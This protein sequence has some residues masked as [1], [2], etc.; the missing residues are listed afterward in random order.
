MPSD[1]S[2][3]V[4][5]LAL[6]PPNQL[7]LIPTPAEYVE[8]C[9]QAGRSTKRYGREWILGQG[10][11]DDQLLT[12]RI[13][14]RGA[15]GV[16]EVYD[17]SIKD[18]RPMAVPAG[19]AVSYVVNLVTLKLAVQPRGSE[20]KL[21]GLIGAFRALLS[22]DREMW[23]VSIPGKVAITYTEW[24]ETVDKVTEVKFHLRKP[25][26]HY[27]DTP[28]LQALLDQAEA[29]SARLR[30]R[31]S[32]G[33]DVSSPFVTQSMKHV[34][35]GYGDAVL[36]GQRQG[37]AGLSETI[38]NSQLNSEESGFAAP[39]SENGEVSADTLTKVLAGADNASGVSQ[40]DSS[41]QEQQSASKQ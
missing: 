24:L 12:G 6:T 1:R 32:E 21:N 36:V 19:L 39:A 9:L 25:N 3:K 4:Y 11:R 37:P 31:S 17:D 22:S 33:L 38:Y 41:D 5:V 16:A 10:K 28:D 23:K 14:F 30:L 26:P 20:I 8:T 27:Q 40:G 15:Q 7:P 13:G 35:L 34:G 2:G 18:F 29:E